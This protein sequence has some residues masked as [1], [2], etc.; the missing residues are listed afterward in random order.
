MTIKSE[1]V[2]KG[3]QV[4]AWIIFVALCIEAGALLVNFVYSIFKPAVIGHL[5]QKLDLTGIYARSEWA[6]YSVYSLILAIALLKAVLFYLV[7]VLTGKF[8]LE[9]PFS[10]VIAQQILRISYFIFSIGLLSYIARETI[11][12]LVK[13]GWEMQSLDSFWNDSQAFM[14]MAA[15]VYIIAHIFS[16]GVELQTENDLTV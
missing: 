15:I 10:E 12:G 5:Y 14:M 16:K 1:W 3:L 8:N 13:R 2:F 6:F 4:I 9:K 11:N 7:I